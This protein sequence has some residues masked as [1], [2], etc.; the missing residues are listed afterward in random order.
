MR[1]INSV[2]CRDMVHHLLRS[3]PFHI[4]CMCGII[5][6]LPDIDHIISYYWLKELDGRFLHT[7][8]LIWAGTLIVIM[9]S[10]Y[11]GLYAKL[12][13]KRGKNE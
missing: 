10:Y 8:L 12:V 9:C 13:L 1:N 11:S 2:R 6:L 4:G 5:S 3:R 7:P